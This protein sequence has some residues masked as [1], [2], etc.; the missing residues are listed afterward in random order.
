LIESLRSLSTRF[1][2]AGAAQL[3]CFCF[4]KA[5]L[6]NGRATHASRR[7]HD[8]HRKPLLPH[9]LDESGWPVFAEIWEKPGAGIKPRGDFAR[10]NHISFRQRDGLLAGFETQFH[11]GK[12]SR[13][14]AFGAAAVVCL[15]LL[16]LLAVVQ[17]AH[18]HPLQSDADTCPL[19]V[20]MHSAAPVAAGAVLVFLFSASTPTSI[21]DE[22]VVVRHRHPKLFTRPPPAGC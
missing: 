11:S 17:V 13:Y 2:S 6:S 9:S 14:L 5:G 12:R 7:S 21:V 22:R 8:G 19:C 10:P 15:V 18:V 3:A 4:L 20:V 1:G 16:A